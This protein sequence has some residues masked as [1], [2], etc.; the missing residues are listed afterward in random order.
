MN[1]GPKQTGFIQF[2]AQLVVALLVLLAAQLAFSFYAGRSISIH[3]QA[4]GISRYP[5]AGGEHKGSHERDAAPQRGGDL[6]ADFGQW[7]LLSFGALMF[8]LIM[9][10]IVL[11]VVSVMV[12]LSQQ[13]M[14]WLTAA[15]GL[16]EIK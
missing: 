8:F 3:L 16:I 13:E 7:V 11:L 12:D 15:W 4:R 2:L 6:V 14:K 9:P 10:L 5:E 1:I